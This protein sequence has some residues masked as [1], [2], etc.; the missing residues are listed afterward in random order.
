MT[1]DSNGMLIVKAIISLAHSLKMKVIAEGVETLAHL[2]QLRSLGCD[3]CQ[4]FLFGRPGP[5]RVIEADLRAR[6][7]GTAPEG[8]D[9]SATC[10]ELAHPVW[11][12][13]LA[14]NSA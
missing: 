7:G 8:L 13:L 3:Q 6:A 9:P 2:E 1:Q 12:G 14:A 4:G 11:G 5:A 10:A